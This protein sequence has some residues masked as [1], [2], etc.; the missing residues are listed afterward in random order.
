MSL[1]ANTINL[2]IIFELRFLFVLALIVKISIF[3][4]IKV[5]LAT[6]YL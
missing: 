2:R 3:S 1:K 6:K 4:Q 5:A